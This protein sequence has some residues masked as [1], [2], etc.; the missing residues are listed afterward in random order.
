M[1]LVARIFFQTLIAL[2]FFVGAFF[3]FALLFFGFF[4]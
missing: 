1:R 2:G 3:L 4:L